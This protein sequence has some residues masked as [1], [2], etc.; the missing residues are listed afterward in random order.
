MMTQ[1][2]NYLRGFCLLLLFFAMGA[3]L[4][5]QTISTGSI[6]GTI[7]D[8]SGAVLPD[9]KVT[10]TNVGT[11]RVQTFTTSDRGAYS[12]GP[13]VPGNYL[14]RVEAKGFR[15]AEL[16][17]N[18]V[19]GAVTSGN[20]KMQVGQSEQTVEV[21][22]ETL[23]VN[24][25]QPTVQGV[26]NA[27]QI[28]SLPISG[29]NFLD[30]A[31]LEP[32]VQIQDGGTF[33]PTK[34]G[35]S[36]ISFGGRY[37]RTAR[38]EVDG[39]DISDET[40]G[41]TTQNIP[42][43]SI[44]EFQISQ[45]TLDP[46]TEL[47]SSG[48]V[49]VVT[50]SGTNTLHGNGF[51]LFRD[52]SV[53][54]NFPGGQD[55][56]FQRNQY[57]GSL[58]GPFVKDKLFFFANAERVKQDLSVP[59]APPAPF[60]NLPTGYA[61]PFRDI[62]TL[63]KL[64]YNLSSTAHLF[65]RFTYESVS[66]TR[67]YGATYQP[68]ANRSQTPAHGVGFDFATAGI[69]HSVRFGF[70]K[71]QN[72]I[73]DAVTTTGVF[74][75]ASAVGAN[76][77]IR[78]GGAGTVTRFGPSRLAPQA[79]FQSNYSLKYDGSK[80][81]KSHIFRFGVAFNRIR[82]GGFASF[83]GLAPEARTSISASAQAFAATG[84]YPGGASNPLNYA[85]N[86][87]LMGNGQGFFTETPAFNYPA[88]GQFDNRIGIYFADAWKIKPTFTI[89]MALRWQRD[90][91]RT[92]SD[93]PP[94][95]CDQI[96]AAAFGGLVPC[97][98]KDLILDQFGG[99]S[100]GQRVRQPNTNFGPQAGFAWDVTGS[101]KTVIRGG[102]GLY[103]ENAVF[104]NI[105]FDRPG[106]LPKGLF[107]GTASLCPSGSI[108]VGGTTIT[109]VNG[110][111]I[112]TGICGQRV[113]D[114]AKL[115]E[116][117]Q[118][119]YQA[120]VAAA[121]VSANPNFLGVNLANGNNSTGNNFIEPNYR[122]P[123][124]I[125]MNI[126]V[127]H[128]FGAGTVLSV[129]FLRN[130]GEHYLLGVDTN[131]VGDARYLNKVAAQ[132]A[133]AVTLSN[134][135]VGSIDA[136]LL[137]GACAYD[138][139]TGHPLTTPRALTIDDFASN[140]L[141]SGASYLFAFPASAFGLTPDTG[142]AFPGINPLVGE[143]QMLFSIG[144]STYTAL[145]ASLRQN[146][147]Q[148]MRYVRGANF[149]VSYALGRFNSMAAD[150]D[151]VNNAFDFRNPTKYY[152][153]NSLDRTSQL[154]FGGSFDLFQKGPSL[155][156][157]GH[158]FSPLNQNMLIEDQGRAGEIFHTDLTGDGTTGDVLPGTNLG[159]FGRSVNAGSIN[160]VI[161]AYNSTYGGKLTPAGQAL[162]NAGLFTEAQLVALGATADLVP[163]APA[164][165]VDNGWL[166]T[167]DLKVGWPVRIG[168]RFTIEPSVA[169]FNVFNFA[170]F[171]S[172]TNQ[173]T[174]TLSGAGGS[175][176]GT[177]SNPIVRNANRIG[178]GTGVNS[179]GSPRAVEFGLRLTF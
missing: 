41:T 174:P 59:L 55:T 48:A 138:P 44:Q 153:P 169:F 9:V 135:G 81:Y 121:G 32:G 126:G 83:Y 17:L 21:S 87:I 25:E 96:D 108:N 10:V 165:Q 61:S 76:I 49:N 150:Q 85:I 116:T 14:V 128:E 120:A 147:K 171:D 72:H 129:D 20:I 57:G 27:Q 47:T 98:G 104:N 164:G 78:N 58:G 123:R 166:K 13:I 74:N 146:L 52:K 82:G 31:S 60:N 101:G 154:S 179:V 26:L 1:V 178:I 51:Y 112:A 140:G 40:V 86:A 170:N 66:D 133:I 157:V 56:Y 114:V 2:A 43:G 6:Q 115:I 16:S 12:T 175:I 134:C 54:A 127:Q 156:F 110:V 91:G 145:Q 168:E 46:S 7:T 3:N 167:M 88:G 143:N 117:L 105:L 28:D 172:P 37:G 152:G 119:N 84:P 38:I 99:G 75:P 159:A 50:K 77:A 130:V 80:L 107:W 90:T 5:A 131:H 137:P 94:M 158:I 22:A 176:N 160:N 122:T 42:A 65:Y 95:T 34:N 113:G 15:T 177:T 125:Q 92:D 142:A 35:F 103:F 132:N 100:Y 97:T 18:V 70:L 136:G 8:P 109:S 151:F 24:T 148:P 36:S 62:M 124:S 64:D 63:G 93:L 19:I 39:I 106:K 163:L 155:S 149:Q 53:M 11:N 173:M 139:V 141:D 111:D 144:R 73:A 45:S 67:A 89:T 79:T 29:R 33:D 71:F 118:K 161:S 102:A 68:F 69:T 30:L 23:R 162:V 4:N